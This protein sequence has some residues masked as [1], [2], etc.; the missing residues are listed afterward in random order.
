MTNNSLGIRISMPNLKTMDIPSLPLPLY[1]DTHTEVH[2]FHSG[3]VECCV[4]EI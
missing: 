1:L 3:L 4:I 2:I